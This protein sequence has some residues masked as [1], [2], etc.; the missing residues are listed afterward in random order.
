MVFGTRCYATGDWQA[1]VISADQSADGNR[2]NIHVILYFSHAP[3]IVD[4]FAATFIWIPL[5]NFLMFCRSR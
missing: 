4:D 5:V 3:P 1:V 2:R